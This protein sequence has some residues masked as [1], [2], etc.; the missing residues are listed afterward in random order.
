MS[1][2]RLPVLAG[3]AVL[4]L[5]TACGGGG[6]DPHPGD[7]PAQTLTS[8]DPEAAAAELLAEMSLEEKVGQLFVPVLVGTTAEE[9]AD[10]VGRYHP[11]G[12]IYFPDNLQDPAQVATMSNGLQELA[13]AS[14]A[15]I[16]L[17][18]GVDEEQGMV[19]R[20][21]FGARFPDAMAVGATRDPDKAA[22]LASTTA[23]Q[24]SA[25]G[26]NLDYAPVADVNVNADNPVIGIRSFGSDPDLVGELAAAEAE[27]FQAGGV[28]AVAK[29]FPGH[30]DTDVDSHTGLP[31]IDKTRED[32]E[33]IDLPPFRR[34]VEADIDMIMTAHVLMPRLDSS[35][36]P[37]TLSP[38]LITGVLREEL[39]YD[40]VVTTDALNM[41]GVRQSHDDGEVAVRAVLAGAD[42]LLM[43][44]DLDL[45]Y[46]AVLAAVEEGRI[47]EERLDESVLR[48]LRLKL[49]RGLLDAEPVDP[50]AAAGVADHTGHREAAQRTADASVTLLRNNGVLPL[51]EGASVR[52][53]G[54]GGERIGA[55]LE[56]LGHPLAAS[57]SDADV[58]VV[59][60]DGARGDAEQR[61]LVAQ[62]RASGAPVVVVAQGTPYDISALPELDAYL[63]VYSS[64]EV[65]RTAAA[66]V[67]A[68]TVSPSGRLPVDIPGTDLV[69]GDG[70]GY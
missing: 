49:R 14:G 47:G 48:I 7:R 54:P 29:H 26:I 20:L 55:A 42:Q 10:V 70:L 52:V 18:L 35:E 5:T 25:V 63:A 67:I 8:T 1:F 59:G 11:G 40:G 9:N 24:L 15:G 60:T 41:E 16:P 30:G 65:S 38:D 56:D 2:R 34:L 43:P 61:D 17:F 37:A 4:L 46:S 32:W 64:M 28:V 22:E 12:F 68:G 50:E 21:P 19:S 23:E 62:A 31:V 51:A 33:R 36:E 53:L 13:A 69:F 27:A 39:G 3:A 66:R 58:V 45:A 57:A 6:T 44:P